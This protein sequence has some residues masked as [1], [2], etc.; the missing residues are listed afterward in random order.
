M[1]DIEHIILY[2]I[3]MKISE[4]T[5]IPTGRVLA[6]IPDIQFINKV[7][8]NKDPQN[9]AT[10]FPCVG[11]KY[12][13]DVKYKINKYGDKHKILIT[14][15]VT[16]IYEPLGEIW[17]PLTIYLFTNSRKE[18]RELGSAIGFYLASTPMQYTM[19]D[20]LP[21]EYFSIIYECY[22]DLNEL[23]PYVRAYDL[24]INSRMLQEVSGY[25]VE[26]INTNISTIQGNLTSEP[27]TLTNTITGD[28]YV[29]E[30]VTITY[31]ITEDDI[32]IITEDGTDI[33][34]EI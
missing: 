30:D 25:I 15:T 6:K 24:K 20:Q 2:T 26:E 34:F 22:R 29:N 11:M 8:G 32:S 33:A 21:G 1:R 23:R 19:A 3:C 7:D 13:G 9:H 4:V 12:S 10:K 18:Q 28:T 14:P 31:G 17:I 5:G 16:R 27:D